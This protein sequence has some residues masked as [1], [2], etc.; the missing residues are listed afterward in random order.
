MSTRYSYKALDAKGKDI[1]G[2]LEAEKPEDVGTWLSDRGYIVVEIT[3]APLQAITNRFG[4]FSSKLKIKEKDMNLLLIQ[5]A[6]LINSG[7]P[8]LMSLK[9]LSK[10]ISK[11]VIKAVLKDIKEKIE[12]GKSFSEALK[13]HSQTFPPLLITMVEVGEIGGL[14]DEVLE[15]YSH[16]FDA[17]YKLK[18]KC[19]QSMIY[20]AI[21]LVCTIL[22]IWALLVFVFP[23]FIEGTKKKGT[24]LPG[25]TQ[26]VLNI[27]NFLS[28]YWPHI[29]IG[30]IL[31]FFAWSAIRRTEKGNRII[32]E[33]FLGIPLISEIIKSYQIALFTRILGTLLRCGVPI[34]TSLQAVEKALGNIIYK[35][36][37]AETREAVSRGE[38]LSQSIGKHRELYPESLILMADVGERGGNIG[39]M[40][41]KAGNIYERDIE[42]AL[43]TAVT[44]IQPLMILILGVMIVTIAFAMYL[45][46]FDIAK[47]VG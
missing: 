17:K 31:A 18:K 38:S 23:V 8:L 32:T 40:L 39:D 25:V 35:E 46:L 22:V 7:C 36:S 21:L 14:L 19:V 43:E 26:F 10:Q 13:S 15:R 33:F 34:L 28:G 2:F 4:F 41:E 37:V 6:N 47:T 44:F 29:G 24:E 1:N 3:P 5:L 42:M 9:A 16:I 11:P 12:S 45:P 27:S 20:P 30:L